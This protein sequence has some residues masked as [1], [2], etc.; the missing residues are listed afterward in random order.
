MCHFTRTRY[1]NPQIAPPPLCQISFAQANKELWEKLSDTPRYAALTALRDNCRFDLNLEVG[2]HGFNAA[3]NLM[4]GSGR[5]DLAT[6][7]L[8]IKLPQPEVCNK[9]TSE[10]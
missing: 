3:E 7:R 1:H 8:T 4:L 2:E 10:L 9:P 6:A 5:S